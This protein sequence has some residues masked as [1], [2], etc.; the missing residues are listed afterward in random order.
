MVSI[1]RNWARL[2]NLLFGPKVIRADIYRYIDIDIDIYIDIDIDIVAQSVKAPKG[3][4]W[5]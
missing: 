2:N 4:D 1:G 3:G 5:R